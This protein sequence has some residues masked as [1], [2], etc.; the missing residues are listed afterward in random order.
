MVFKKEENNT[1]QI[2]KAVCSVSGY[3]NNFIIYLISQSM[4]IR[5][6]LSVFAIVITTTASAQYN[7]YLK[8]MIGYGLSNSYLPK[9]GTEEQFTNAYNAGLHIGIENA[10]WRFETGIR[11]FTTGYQYKEAFVTRPDDPFGRFIDVDYIRCMYRHIGLPVAVQLK[12]RL[13]EKLSI[14]P[15]IQLIPAY[16]TGVTYSMSP[17][18]Y[19][20]EHVS[21]QEFTSTFHRFSVFGGAAINF[22]YKISDMLAVTAGPALQYTLTSIKQDYQLYGRTYNE[23][24][25]NYAFTF[26]AGIKWSFKKKKTAES[27]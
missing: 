2:V 4:Q 13:S 5:N 21:G 20:T 25:L 1:N 11:Y 3:Y 10:R 23:E 9:A 22:E 12:K 15:S 18:I 27:K 7:L 17:R 19:E 8:P 16:N 24:Q 6:I 26:D 14:L